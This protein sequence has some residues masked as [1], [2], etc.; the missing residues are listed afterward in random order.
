[1]RTLIG[2]IALLVSVSLVQE[3]FK[4]VENQAER[5]PIHDSAKQGKQS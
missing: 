3:L 4:K 5:P 2:I 1:M